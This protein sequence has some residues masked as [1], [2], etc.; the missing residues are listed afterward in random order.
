MN[1]T[2]TTVDI[3]VKPRVLIA[4]DS[5]IVR[6]TLIKRVEGMFEFREAVDGEQA[7]ETLLIDPNIRVVIT[8]LTMPKLDGYGLLGR[9]RSSKITRIR[10]MP[11]VVV[12][13]SDEKEERDRALAAG[14]SDLIT[15]GMETAQLLSRLD[16]LAKLVTTQQEF[17]QSLEALVAKSHPEEYMELSTPTQL[18]ER[19]SAMRQ[20]AIEH[21]RNFVLLDVRV[22][23][24]H[25]GLE[26]IPAMPPQTVVDAVG[27]LLQHTVRQSDCVAHTGDAEFTVVTGSIHADSAHNFAR[28]ICHA[29]ANANLVK[30]KPMTFVASCGLVSWSEYSDLPA[31]RQPSLQDLRERSHIRATMGLQHGLTG[32]VGPEEEAAFQHENRHQHKPDTPALTNINGLE[33]DTPPDLSTLL[34][35]LKEGRRELVLQHIGTLSAE[36]Q[37]LVDL[38][39]EQRKV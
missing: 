37:P 13:G 21:A 1:S 16:I 9:I 26:G 7:W 5:R 34:Q 30:D 18:N 14:A 33:N 3:T 35:W 17:E 12:S 25:T 24:K 11:V 39:L 19:A 15:K 23:L 20:A 6:A 10:T 2:S 29:V 28:R 31:D 22:G 27:Q 38:M 32:V 8:D 4:D 36:L